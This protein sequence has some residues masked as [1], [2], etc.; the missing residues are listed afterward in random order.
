MDFMIMDSAGNAI[1]SYD[2]DGGAMQALITFAENDAR[3]AATL[4]VLAFDDAGEL[5]GDPITVA[6]L[7]PEAAT[8]L[9]MAGDEWTYK[10]ALSVSRWAGSSAA[11][12]KNI[13]GAAG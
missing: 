5:V 4:A 2:S 13:L 9:T 3:A 1:E 7:R 12:W 10:S 6:D 11:P 8:K